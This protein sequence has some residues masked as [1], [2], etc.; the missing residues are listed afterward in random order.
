MK[1][2]FNADKKIKLKCKQCGKE[3][4]PKRSTQIY[5]SQ[6]CYVIAWSGKNT[7]KNNQTDLQRYHHLLKQELRTKY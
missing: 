1:S 5:C 3:F 2:M 4:F 7:K 6:E